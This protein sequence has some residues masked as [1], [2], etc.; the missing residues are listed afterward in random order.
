M[1]QYICR[2]RP[3][4]TARIGRGGQHFESLVLQI[5]PLGR[6]PDCYQVPWRFVTAPASGADEEVIVADQRIA[7]SNPAGRASQP[8]QS[9]CT[10]VALTSESQWG[11]IRA[12]R[13][14]PAVPPRHCRRAQ[15]RLGVQRYLA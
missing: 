1:S 5:A 4:G 11:G 3:A 10:C 15:V 13:K 6:D 7:G 2:Y 14:P 8:G 9:M 12:C